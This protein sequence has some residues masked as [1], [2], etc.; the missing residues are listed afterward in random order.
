MADT[1]NNFQLSLGIL[2]A[3]NLHGAQAL[4]EIAGSYNVVEHRSSNLSPNLHTVAVEGNGIFSED[5]FGGGGHGRYSYLN[6]SV[7]F[8]I[9]PTV[10]LGGVTLPTPDGNRGGVSVRGGGQLRVHTSYDSD[11]GFLVSGEAGAV[12]GPD[13]AAPMFAI[14]V[15]GSF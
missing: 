9:G 2:A 12:I 7:L 3:A 11:A 4:G 6:Q 1:S 14:S 8:S 10:A 13:V 15:G 5:G